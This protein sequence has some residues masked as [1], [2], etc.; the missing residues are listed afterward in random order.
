[1]LSCF[2]KERKHKIVW[3]IR[4]TVISPRMKLSC[5]EIIMM[6]FTDSYLYMSKIKEIIFLYLNFIEIVYR[7]GSQTFFVHGALRKFTNT[8]G[9]LMKPKFAFKFTKKLYLNH[10]HY[11]KCMKMSALFAKY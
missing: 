9:A 4:F 8:R 1:M 7:S 5:N 6:K 11:S 3:C 10:V 2:P